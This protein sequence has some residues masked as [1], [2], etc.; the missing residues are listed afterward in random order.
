MPTSNVQVFTADL[1]EHGEMLPVSAARLAMQVT[2]LTVTCSSCHGTDPI[3]RC[4]RY[5]SCSP[6]A[7]LYSLT[8]R[9]EELYKRVQYYASTASPRAKDRFV[10]AANSF[11][12]PYWDWARGESG[13]PVPDFFTTQMIDIVRP[14][15]QKQELWNPL[16]S[17]YFHPL[18]PADFDSKVRSSKRILISQY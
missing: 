9:Q 7:R 11:R 6:Q 14:N 4:L 12:M 3:L 15:G 17:F 13:G 8:S 18:I 2:A 5:V 16:Y 10:A 1:L